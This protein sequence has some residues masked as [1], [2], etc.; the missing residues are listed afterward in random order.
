L[1]ADGAADAGADVRVSPIP[2]A[3]PAPLSAE[4]RVEVQAEI[5]EAVESFWRFLETP[6]LDNDDA[7]AQRNRAIWRRMQ[8]IAR[9]ERLLA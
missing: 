3:A 6:P 1:V 9:L 5:D 8:A 4:E 2:A 7:R